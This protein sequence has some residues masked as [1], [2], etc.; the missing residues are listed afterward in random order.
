MFFF[1]YF[2]KFRGEENVPIQ[3]VNCD[4]KFAILGTFN[5]RVLFFPASKFKSLTRVTTS[6]FGCWSL[7]YGVKPERE[8]KDNRDRKIYGVVYGC[9]GFCKFCFFLGFS[10]FIFLLF[11]FFVTFGEFLEAFFHKSDRQIYKTEK[12]KIERQKEKISQKS[13]DIDMCVSFCFE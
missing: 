10:V 7:R 4:T 12:E 5:K 3:F 6:H 8:N 2:F 11:S 9:Y 13:V 1:G